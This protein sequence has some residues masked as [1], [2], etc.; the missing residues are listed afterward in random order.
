MRQLTFLLFF[1][2]FFSFAQDYPMGMVW[3][4]ESYRSIPYKV[5]FTAATYT[6]LPSSY[7]LEQYAPTPGNQ[8]RYGTCVA[9][10]SAYGLRTIMLAKDLGLTDKQTITANALSP[11]FV[12]SII[13]REDDLDCSKGANPKFGLE[14]LKVAGAPTLRSLPYQCNPEISTE[15]Q[16]EAIDYRIRDYQTLF[17]FDA[18]EYGQKTN[19]TK[20]ALSEGYPVLLGM[21]LPQSFFKATNTWRSLEAEKGTVASQHGY[22]AMVVIGYD[23]NYE[24][25]AFRLMNSWGTTWGDGG[26]IWVPYNEYEAWAMGALQPYSYY[27][28]KDSNGKPSLPSVPKTI[29]NTPNQP[30]R[31]ELPR[32][33]PN[34]PNQPIRPTLPAGQVDPNPIAGNLPEGSLKFETNTGAPMEVTRVSTRNLFVDDDVEG[35][36][37]VAYRMK[38]SYASGTRF[39]FYLNNINEGYIYAFATDLTQKINK[40]LP[41]ED[42]MSPLIG[43]NSELAFPSEKK[44]IRMD[45]NPGTDYL[46]ILFSQQKLDEK[47]LIDKMQNTEGSLTSKIKAALGEVL[48]DKSMVDYASGTPGFK[49]KEGAQGYVVPLMVEITH[50]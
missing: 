21:K 15:V 20:K 27:V 47:E 50:N 33:E 5:E 19:A 45:N 41:F 11:S 13:K 40:I 17:F 32:V 10:A 14:A 39:R 22:H 2:S 28:R 35:E 8:G 1:I 12:Y 36:D 44:V 49:V 4:E 31:P 37:L 18:Q 25:G 7:S 24:G 42:G 38:E 48:I 30:N 34:N 3:D 26:F 43:A 29:P 9:Y 23:D 46:L 16:L 6:N